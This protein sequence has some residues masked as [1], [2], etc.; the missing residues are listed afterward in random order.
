MA[1][2]GLRLKTA[3][4]LRIDENQMQNKSSQLPSFLQGEL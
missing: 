4:Y 1:N 2:K 3:I